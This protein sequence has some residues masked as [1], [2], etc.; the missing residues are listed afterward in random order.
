MRWTGRSRMISWL[1]ETAGNVSHSMVVCRQELSGPNPSLHYGFDGWQEPIRD[2][3]LHYAG[4]GLWVGEVHD[5][6]GHV[7]LD[8]AIRDGESWDN[9]SG[10]DYRLWIGLDVLDSH[11]HISGSGGGD[12]GIASYLKAADSA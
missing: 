4:P 11:L 3:P 10:L 1:D 2:T 5:L 6:E 9:N 12:L 7:A 8:C